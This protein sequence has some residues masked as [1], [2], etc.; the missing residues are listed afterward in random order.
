MQV[1]SH[2]EYNTLDKKTGVCA[3]VHRCIRIQCKISEERGQRWRKE[4]YGRGGASGA[5]EMTADC[6]AQ[7]RFVS[8]A[9]ELLRWV[10]ARSVRN[11]MKHSPEKVLSIEALQFINSKQNRQ[12]I[13]NVIG[14]RGSAWINLC[15]LSC[16]TKTFSLCLNL[17]SV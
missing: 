2:N 4:E 14:E 17:N 1:Y 3:V 13:S 8:I 5:L 12:G 15:V 11:L 10:G 7:N 6:V 16:K 9:Y